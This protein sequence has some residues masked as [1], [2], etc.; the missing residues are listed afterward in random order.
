MMVS[1]IFNLLVELEILFY[2]Y[3]KYICHRQYCRNI[4][5]RILQIAVFLRFYIIL[6]M[7][8]PE[9]FTDF[10]VSFYLR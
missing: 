8:W 6:N 3:Y 10:F 9:L 7:I 5:L 2:L 1:G 4:Q